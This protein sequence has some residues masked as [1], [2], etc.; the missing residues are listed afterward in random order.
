[1]IAISPWGTHAQ[2]DDVLL[3]IEALS[4]DLPSH[5]Y[6]RSPDPPAIDYSFYTFS[7]TTVRLAYASKNS[8][9][10]FLSLSI[11]FYRVLS[12]STGLRDTHFSHNFL[13]YLKHAIGHNW[14]FKAFLRIEWIGIYMASTKGA[15]TTPLIYNLDPVGSVLELG[16]GITIKPFETMT[17]IWIFIHWH[18]MFMSRFH[19]RTNENSQVII[20]LIVAVNN[21]RDAS[22]RYE[23]IESNLA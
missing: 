13:Q 21:L 3:L 15:K 7:R 14:S 4:I 1:M 2:I 18:E 11:Y 22:R 5:G 6:K 16:R 9:Y 19:L 10:L 23:S 17:M 12:L 8:N 20:N